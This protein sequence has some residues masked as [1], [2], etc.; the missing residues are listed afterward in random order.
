MAGILNSLNIEIGGAEEEA[1]EVLE[2]A[3]EM[4]VEVDGEDDEART[5]VKGLKGHWDP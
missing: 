3:L 4:E 1:A 5:R 2:A